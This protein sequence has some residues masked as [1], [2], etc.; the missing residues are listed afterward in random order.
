MAAA[1]D[2]EIHPA[3]PAETVVSDVQM[4]DAKAVAQRYEGYVELDRSTPSVYY[5]RRL[6]PKNFLEG[7][8]SYNPATRLRQMLAR[9]GIVV[10]IFLLTTFQLVSHFFC[11]R[12]L[13]VS[14]MVSVRAVQLRQALT[15]CTKG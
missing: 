10:Y 12:S 4:F 14:A 2:F 8:L 13:P 6:D 7:P 11:Y 15:V 3:S 5:N 1:L 9:P